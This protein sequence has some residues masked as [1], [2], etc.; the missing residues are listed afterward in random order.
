MTHKNTTPRFR[1][2][3]ILIAPRYPR[4]STITKRGKESMILERKREKK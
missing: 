3:R 2:S 1:L 4:I